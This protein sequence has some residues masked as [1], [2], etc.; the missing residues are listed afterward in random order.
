MFLYSGLS[1]LTLFEKLADASM[2][3]LS[4][5][6]ITLRAMIIPG[7]QTF[8]LPLRSLMMYTGPLS[9]PIR[10]STLLSLARSLLYL[11]SPLCTS[12]ARFSG[13]S[14]LSSKPIAM[15]SPVGST[16]VVSWSR[17]LKLSVSSINL[18]RSM[19][20]RAWSIVVLVGSDAATMSVKNQWY[21]RV[22]GGIVTSMS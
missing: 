13:F 4:A 16:S 7:P 5:R 17:C 15:P 12:I 18:L 21:S 14:G 20:F 9:R 10:S 11:L 3:M 6:S 2:F 8:S 1:I 19:I 22:T